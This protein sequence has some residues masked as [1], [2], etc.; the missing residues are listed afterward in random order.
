MAWLKEHNVDLTDAKYEEW[1]INYDCQKFEYGNIF[2]VGDAAG[3]TSGLTGEGIYFAMVS[4]IEAAK[5]I[6][7]PGYK[8]NGIKTILQIKRNHERLLSSLEFCQTFSA[9]EMEIASLLTK[10]I[11]FNKKIIRTYM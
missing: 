5:K 8:L 6:I 9:I 10:M 4:G 11:V 2:L 3:F 7:N 1:T